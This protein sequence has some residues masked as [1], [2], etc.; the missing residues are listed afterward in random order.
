MS[1]LNFDNLLDCLVSLGCS[2]IQLVYFDGQWHI[3]KAGR[4]RSDEEEI[5][6]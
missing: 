2:A 3:D 5:E 4:I 1:E 6:K